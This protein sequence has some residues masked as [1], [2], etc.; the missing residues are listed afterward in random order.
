[1]HILYFS[2]YCT[3]AVIDFVVYNNLIFT[4]LSGKELTIF[5]ISSCAVFLFFLKNFCSSSRTQ[6]VVE[7][8]RT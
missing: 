6:V 4:K 5:S 1:M 7:D 8:I 3:P 2:L